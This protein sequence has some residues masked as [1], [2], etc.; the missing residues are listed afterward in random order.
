MSRLVYLLVS[1]E[2][3]EL[4]NELTKIFNG[5]KIDRLNKYSRCITVLPNFKSYIDLTKKFASV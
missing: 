3:D 5:T 1:L 2:T 4:L